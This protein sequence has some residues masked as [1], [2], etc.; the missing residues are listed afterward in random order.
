MLI[1]RALLYPLHYQ[2]RYSIFTGRYTDT[3]GINFISLV[4][5]I[6]AN[7]A[8]ISKWIHYATKYNIKYLTV[9][10]YDKTLKREIVVDTR[11]HEEKHPSYLE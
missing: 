11:A 10:T 7:K 6:H 1:I 4:S 2:T 3:H 9:Y 8:L 5:C